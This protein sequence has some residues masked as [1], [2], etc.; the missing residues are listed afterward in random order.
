MAV[1]AALQLADSLSL[2]PPAYKE[3]GWQEAPVGTQWCNELT[4]PPSMLMCKN[5]SDSNQP[6]LSLAL[7]VSIK[8]YKFNYT[9]R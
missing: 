8:P 4:N 6:E 1:P 5:S 9:N 2:K 7:L 3:Q